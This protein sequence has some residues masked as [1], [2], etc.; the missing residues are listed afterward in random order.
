MLRA[1]CEG[2]DEASL[3]GRENVRLRG[4][5]AIVFSAVMPMGCVSMSGQG[6]GEL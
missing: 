1:V 5:R 3:W 4:S 2:D 6:V